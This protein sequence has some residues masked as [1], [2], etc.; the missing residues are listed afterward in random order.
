MKIVKK[1]DKVKVEYTGKLED[2]TVFDSSDKHGSL[3]EFTVGE[4]QLIKGFDEALLGMHAGEIKEIKLDPKNAYGEYNPEF[5]K[6]LPKE[7]FPQDQEIEPGMVF[8]IRLQDGHRVPM[9]II[10][11]SDETV[12]IDLNPPLTGKTLFFKIKLVEIAG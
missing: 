4:G 8:S 7:Y 2:G 10:D 1:G 9:R 6:E 11:V 12:T 5:V 3:L